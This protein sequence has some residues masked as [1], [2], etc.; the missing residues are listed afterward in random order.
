[1]KSIAAQLSP[2]NIVPKLMD[3]VLKAFRC[4]RVGRKG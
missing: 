2:L 3:G 1:M 4:D